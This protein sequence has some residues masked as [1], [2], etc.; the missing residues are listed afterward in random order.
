MI[1]YTGKLNEHDEYI[2]ILNKIEKECNYIEIVVIDGKKSNELINSFKEDIIECIKVSKW[3]GTE[4]KR[5]NNLYK[6]KSS[7]SFFNYLKKYETFCKYYEYGS[8]EENLIRGDYSVVTDFGLDDI[9][10]Y[11]SN[12]NC[13]LCTTTHEGY[14]AINKE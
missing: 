10:F 11:D 3:W 6:I 2:K 5:K 8:N 1:D 12:N 7:K 14:I 4:T 9:A 13:I